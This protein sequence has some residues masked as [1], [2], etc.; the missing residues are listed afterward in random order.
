[1]VRLSLR[2]DWACRWPLRALARVVEWTGRIGART[3]DVTRIDEQ[4]LVGGGVSR[5]GYAR[6]RA[7]GITHVIDV[8]A[9]RCDD[10]EALAAVGIELLHLPTPDRSALSIEALFQ[11]VNWALSRLGNGARASVFCHCEH[12]VGRGPLMA[13][14]ILVA[15]GWEVAAAYRL[16]RRARWQVRLN[17]RQIEGLMRFAEAWG[18][19]VELRGAS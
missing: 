1:M 13:A 3:V 11:G 5:A 10:A 8:R 16:V 9:E 4:L 7:M 2:Y 19:Q 6:L 18:R 14:A 17:D 15:Q 12:G